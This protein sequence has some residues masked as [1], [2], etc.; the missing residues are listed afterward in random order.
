MEMPSFGALQAHPLANSGAGA[1]RLDPDAT[2]AQVQAV[3]LPLLGRVPYASRLSV[4]QF[5]PLQNED[6]GPIH[7]RGRFIDDLGA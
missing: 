7:P 4:P 3:T 1:K 5:L 2:S 6:N